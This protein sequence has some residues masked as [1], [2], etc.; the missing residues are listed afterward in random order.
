MRKDPA[1]Y[2]E[3]TNSVGFLARLTFRAFARA[4]E[5]RTI[6]KGVTIGQWRFLRVL[7]VEDGLTQRELSRRVGLREPTT[8]TALRSMERDGLILREQSSQDRRRVHVY[9]T[10]KAK[11]LRRGLLPAVAEVNKI[12]AAGIPD[13]DLDT[14]QRT[15]MQIV[16]NLAAEEGEGG[17]AASEEAP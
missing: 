4:L 7:W 6:K 11:R 14:L 8:V 2:E 13:A 10:T 3:P 17:D 12:A 5:R 16:A 9:L 15:L 1:F